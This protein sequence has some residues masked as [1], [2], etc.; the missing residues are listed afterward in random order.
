M[1]IIHG[2]AKVVFPESVG[3]QVFNAL[4]KYILCTEQN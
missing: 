3:K 4:Q 1:Y 2:V